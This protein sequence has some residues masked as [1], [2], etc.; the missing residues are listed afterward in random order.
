MTKFFAPNFAMRRSNLCAL[1]ASDRRFQVLLS[2]VITASLTG[3]L[4]GPGLAQAQ[5]SLKARSVD[6]IVAVVNSEPITNNEVQN[7][8]LRLQKQLQPGT[9]TPN[10]QI[11]TQQA[12]D[13]LIN[14]KAQLQQARDNGIRIDDTEVDQTELNIA[15]QNQVS[16]EELYKRVVLEGLS[17]SAFREQLRNQL[18]ISRLREREVDNRARISDTDVEQSIQSQQAG[19]PMASNQVDIN[20][21]M[22]L[23]AVPENSSE[24]EAADLKIKAQQI[25]QR[26]KRGESFAALAQAFSQAL[27]KGA[28]GGEMGLRPADRYPTLFIDSTQNLNKGEVSD[29]VR[30]GAGFHI[31]KVLDKKQSEMSNTLI[32]QT[33][34]R[35]I[36]L[37]TG[38]ELSEAAARNRLVTYKQ[39]VQ[40]GTDFA[41]LARQFSQDG[42][43][44]SGGDL[45][46]A[47][48]GQ[49]V[50]EFEEVLTSLRPG[51][52][53]DPLISRFGAHLIQ[54]MER[55]EIPLSVREQREMV[56]TQLREKKIEELYAAWVEELRGR[57]YVELRDPPQ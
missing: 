42:S 46:W 54:V 13:Q 27:D 15:R 21:A 38:S 17:V 8:K 7:L 40:A 43:A 25:V 22:I 49:F 23:I 18:M 11:L 44:A 28:N 16:K 26:A 12:L 57:A 5:G 34:A 47:S 1:P 53:S 29:P 48:P 50:P 39:R 24:Q 9:A 30:S 33:R 37:R 6:Y 56:R 45:G 35:H 3:A 14:E 55:R 51:Q 52:I 19:K 10:A 36:L 4:F 41:D 20:L 2:M 31:L 32:V